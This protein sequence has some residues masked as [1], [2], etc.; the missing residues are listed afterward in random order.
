M[1]IKTTDPQALEKL[2]AKLQKLENEQKLMKE[3]N[4]II[5]SSKS[6]EAKIYCTELNS[7]EKN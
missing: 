1:Q 4:T 2:N 7:P 6:E 5:R 3:I